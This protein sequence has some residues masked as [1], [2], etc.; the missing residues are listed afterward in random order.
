MSEKF[1]YQYNAPTKEERQEIDYIRKQYLPQDDTE[2]KIK[3]LHSLHKQVTSIP[4]VIALCFGVVG[5]LIFGLGLTFF[6]ERVS[7][8]YIGI[9]CGLLGIALIIPAYP[10]YIKYDHK[11]RE[12]YG[13]EIIDLSN[14]LL[15]D[16]QE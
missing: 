14:E 4:M 11:L 2:K 12:K 3:R 1:K 5:I 8:W 16:E 10:M 15:N 6:L 9:P 7:Y 13:Q